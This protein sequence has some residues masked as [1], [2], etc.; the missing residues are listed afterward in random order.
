M[1]ININ[2]LSP[3][4]KEIEQIYV[5]IQG[6]GI[7]DDRY[8][9]KMLNVF[10]SKIACF[11]VQDLPYLKT[12]YDRSREYKVLQVG[13]FLSFT[14]PKYPN[15]ILAEKIQDLMSQL[16]FKESADFPEHDRVH[17]SDLPKDVKSLLIGYLPKKDRDSLALTNKQWNA[18][19][20]SPEMMAKLI[21][22]TSVQLTQKQL[23]SA[24]EHCG[25][26]V[27]A[28]N[29]EE[30]LSSQELNT[31]TIENIASLCPRLIALNIPN[32]KNVIDIKALSACQFLEELSLAN[33]TD[34]TPLSTIQSLKALDLSH[35]PIKDISALST[36]RYLHAL[37]LAFTPVED[38]SPLSGCHSLIALTL[39]CT[40][41]CNLKPLQT[42]TS[43]QIL[44]LDEAKN[45]CDITALSALTNLRAL[46]LNNTQ[47]E[48]LSPISTCTKLEAL[49]VARTSVK[50]LEP[51]S[52]LKGLKQLSLFNTKVTDLAPVG[53]CKLLQYLD[54]A[55]SQVKTLEPLMAC[56]NLKKLMAFEL[57]ISP[58][59]I[60]AL[61]QAIPMLSIQTEMPF[62]TLYS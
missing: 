43:L 56:E 59:E 45:V 29:L 18:M 42:C 21:N 54:I 27:T 17:I 8:Y 4:C 13:N 60:T 11:N 22:Q 20:H 3:V 38:L 28:L 62:F 30:L 58:S 57:S 23:I 26:F 44:K 31:E 12:L 35:T 37:M 10:Q 51:I 2:S 36:L 19:A 39:S 15:Q 49:D 5:N 47:V 32:T 52:S 24:L 40:P 53:S 46:T 25:Q 55:S 48:D 16:G 9:S 34:I 61:E 7:T 33:T 41:V 50:N 6:T 14:F 1:S